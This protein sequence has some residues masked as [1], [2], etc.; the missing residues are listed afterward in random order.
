VLLLLLG[1]WGALIPFIGPLFSFGYVPDSAWTWTAA[2]GWFEVLP[3]VVTA[4]GGMLLLISANRITA[5]FGAWLGVA[6]GAWFVVG[7]QLAPVLHAGSL[8]AP[9]ST[10][11]GLRALESLAF[12]YGLGALIVFLAAGALGRLSVR[13]IRDVKAARRR[14]A[15]A[16]RARAA[17]ERAMRERVL[18]EQRRRESEANS[19]A[20]PTTASAPDR[21]VQQN[22][23]AQRHFGRLRRNSDDRTGATAA[24]D[25]QPAPTGEQPS[26][27]A[28]TTRQR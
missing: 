24:N 7:P 10:S 8:G 1:V 28:P 14:E 19:P 5:G 12:F 9:A 3:G 16:A 18:A 23:N 15:E 2:R 20:E 17:E 21:P 27:S 26:G 13:S 6:G 22:R 25:P 4:L 11:S